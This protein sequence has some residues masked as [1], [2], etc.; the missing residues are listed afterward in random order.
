MARKN[1]ATVMAAALAI[2]LAF[3]RPASATWLACTATASFSGHSTEIDLNLGVSGK[4]IEGS[5]VE[6]KPAG[7]RDDIR[8]VVEYPMA[9]DRMPEVTEPNQILAHTWVSPGQQLGLFVL[10]FGQQKFN[11]TNP[12]AYITDPRKLDGKNEL[13]HS[14]KLTKP[15]LDILAT[16]GPGH[17][18]WFDRNGAA[19]AQVDLSFASK[20]MIQSAVDQS[21][22]TAMAYA[23]HKA[24]C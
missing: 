2:S 14:F 13:I 20:A 6:Y 21:Y 11:S 16:G 12:A 4:P 18:T 23:T 19:I 7:G 17:L 1:Q 5:F 9:V 10:T 8:I 24:K 22:P 3:W 15:L